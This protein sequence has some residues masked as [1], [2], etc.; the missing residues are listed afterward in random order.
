MFGG[1]NCA[2]C[3]TEYCKWNKAEGGLTLLFQFLQDNIKSSHHTQ[4]GFP[5]GQGSLTHIKTCEGTAQS[6]QNEHFWNGL[7]DLNPH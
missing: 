6:G 7:P 2:Y 4:L 1:E 5:T 3:Q